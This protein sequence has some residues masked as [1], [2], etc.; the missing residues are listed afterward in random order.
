MDT[1]LAELRRA[2]ENTAAAVGASIDFRVHN[3]T[4]ASIITPEVTD[5]IADIIREELG[6]AALVPPI[7]TAGGEDF[8][9]YPRKRPDLKVGFIGLGADAQPG[10]HAVDMHFDH[11][12]L[13]S[14]V[15]LHKGAIRKILG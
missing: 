14:G 6:E 7:T 4:P 3:I 9:W 5:L 15:K 8:F 2:A 11:T 1:M 13:A 10:L 12:C